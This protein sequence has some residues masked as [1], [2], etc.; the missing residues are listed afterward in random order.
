MR[1]SQKITKKN[2]TK[3][4]YQKDKLAKMETMKLYQ[5]LDLQKE[6]VLKMDHYRVRLLL[7]AI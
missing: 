6:L 2:K 1:V 4:T 3:I 7:V 5:P